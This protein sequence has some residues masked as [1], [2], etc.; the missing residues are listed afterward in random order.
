MTN[1]IYFYNHNTSI[2]IPEKIDKF[3]TIVLNGDSIGRVLEQIADK[4]LL[5]CVFTNSIKYDFVVPSETEAKTVEKMLKT[6]GYNIEDIKINVASRSMWYSQK[7]KKNIIISGNIPFDDKL[8]SFFLVYLDLLNASLSED[9][10]KP[11]VKTI[12]YSNTSSMYYIMNTRTKRILMKSPVLEDAKRICNENPCCVVKN[13]KGEIVHKS[14]FSR[15]AIPNNKPKMINNTMRKTP[16]MNDLSRNL[17]R[18][19]LK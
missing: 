19:R 11:R 4:S 5:F 15:V 2:N 10:N 18:I 12:K 9:D 6:V 14:T 3:P 1:K 7:T 8:Q 17:T 16:S 13:A